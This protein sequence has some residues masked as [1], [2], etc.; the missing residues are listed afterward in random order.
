MTGKRQQ[1]EHEQKDGH[2]PPTPKELTAP[3]KAPTAAVRTVSADS[4]RTRGPGKKAAA[5]LAPTPPSQRLEAFGFTTTKYIT[6]PGAAGGH[7]ET[8]QDICSTGNHQSEGP[9]FDASSSLTLEH[10]GERGTK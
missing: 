1:Q 2:H 9:N 5:A 4:R 8:P 7:T 10:K 3:S 6:V